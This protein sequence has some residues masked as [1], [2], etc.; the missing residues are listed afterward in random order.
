M[1]YI[2][3]PKDRVKEFTKMVDKWNKIEPIEIKDDRFVLPVAVLKIC[4]MATKGVAQDIQTSLKSLPMAELSKTDFKEPKIEEIEPE[5][6][7]K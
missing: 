1:E 6:K 3:I 7:T 2:I 4:S 5:I